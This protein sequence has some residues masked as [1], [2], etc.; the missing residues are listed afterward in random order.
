MLN[1]TDC[2]NCLR[3]SG[4]EFDME[5]TIPKAVV[6]ATIIHLNNYKELLEKNDFGKIPEVK[7]EEVD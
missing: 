7:C 3:Y 4:G 5:V 1:L 6:S 2:I